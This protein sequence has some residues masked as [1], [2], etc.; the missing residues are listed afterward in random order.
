MD[1]DE[2]PR[3]QPP[4]RWNWQAMVM[5]CV[6]AVAMAVPL[7]GV[8]WFARGY[9]VAR[10]QA[11]PKPA[12]EKPVDTSSLE[13]GLEQMSNAQL[14]EATSIANDDGISLIVAKEDMGARIARI[15][16]IAKEAGGGAV[17]LSAADAPVRRV[18]VQAPASRVELLQ[19]AIRGD[20]VDFSAIPA[21][22]STQMFEI[23]LKAP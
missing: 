13:K 22:A 23:N 9:L 8:F 3:E 10:Q 18:M 20:R 12:V 15:A 4:F 21:G 7:A 16:E 17:E 11:V 5:L 14:P 2:E 6:F 1:D 19:R